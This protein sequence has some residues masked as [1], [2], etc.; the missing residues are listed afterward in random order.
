K[1]PKVDAVASGRGIGGE[2][3]RTVLSRADAELASKLVG[4]SV[5]EG[6]EDVAEHSIALGAIFG[7]PGPHR[8][9]S[10][11]KALRVAAALF[12]LACQAAASFGESVRRRVIRGG[13][14][15]VSGTR[16]PTQS[17]LRAPAPDPESYTALLSR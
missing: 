13:K 7:D 3:S 10:I 5:Q 2:K 1:R 4:I 15:A 14:P 8:G 11:G 9:K 17:G 16:D 12:E 6:R